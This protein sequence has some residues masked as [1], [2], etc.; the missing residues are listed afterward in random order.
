MRRVLIF[1]LP[2]IFISS[3]SVA[4]KGMYSS[5][6]KKAIKAYE[7]A[8]TCFNTIDP[9]TGKAGLEC[10][11]Q[12]VLKALHKDTSFTE[13]YSLASNIYVEKGDIEKAIYYKEKMNK[14]KKKVYPQI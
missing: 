6:S 12:Y 13:A 5:K 3:C 11:E 2:I 9:I 14:N 7:S 8:R 10:A 1:L 4:Q